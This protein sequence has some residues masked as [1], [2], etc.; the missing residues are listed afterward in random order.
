MANDTELYAKRQNYL[1][2]ENIIRSV[3]AYVP[4]V[5]SVTI[6]LSEHPWLKTVILGLMGLMVIVQRE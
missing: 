3:G 6:F 5:G 4:F 2:R 1:G